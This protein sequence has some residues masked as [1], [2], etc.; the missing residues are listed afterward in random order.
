MSKNRTFKRIRIL[1]CS[2]NAKI[3]AQTAASRSQSHDPLHP[4]PL[5]SAEK[6]YYKKVDTCMHVYRRIKMKHVV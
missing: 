5:P 4:I 3:K 1:I 2:A 6:V